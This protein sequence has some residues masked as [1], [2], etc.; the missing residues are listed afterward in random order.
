MKTVML[1]VQPPWCEKI[2]MQEKTLEIRK[3]RPNMQ[4][5]FKC[6]IYQTKRSCMYKLL[7]KHG[8]F[9]WANAVMNGRGKVIGDFVCNRIDKIGKRGINNNFDY[10]YLSLNTFGNDDIE[11]EITDIQKSGIPKPELNA[12]GAHSNCLFAWHISD[13]VI[14]DK[15]KDI[16]EF[17][18][19]CRYM[20]DD[21]GSCNYRE[22]A[23][24]HQ[25]FDHNSWPDCS[26]NVV[27][28]KKRL[29]RPPQSWCYVEEL[30]GGE[31]NGNY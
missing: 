1:S 31:G 25:A 24:N 2:A 5:P 13:L 30:E 19:H 15:P 6:Y 23:C 28:C 27:T 11:V 9:K 4:T 8:S 20:L 26:L 29:K 17:V 16:G 22:I 21:M 10:C 3:T 14:Y 7:T 18:P 12:Y